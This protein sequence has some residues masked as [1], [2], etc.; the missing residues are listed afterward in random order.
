MYT[1]M[2]VFVY[3]GPEGFGPRENVWQVSV[4]MHLCVSVRVHARV[5]V[6]VC[7]CVC[8]CVKERVAAAVGLSN[9]FFPD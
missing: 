6:R 1:C 7:V 8:V 9:T 4:G 3:G 5:C 2:E